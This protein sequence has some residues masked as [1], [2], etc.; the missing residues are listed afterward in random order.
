MRHLHSN[1][2][3]LYIFG[4]PPMSH[5][6]IIYLTLSFLFQTTHQE[7]KLAWSYD[8]IFPFCPHIGFFHVTK[9][10]IEQVVAVTCNTCHDLT[11]LNKHTTH[12]PLTNYHTC[13][14]C[15]ILWVEPM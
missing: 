5:I 15:W 8:Y 2:L 3:Q 11:H 12:L 10:F 14:Y 6:L 7:N 4:V 1:K 13:S 9:I